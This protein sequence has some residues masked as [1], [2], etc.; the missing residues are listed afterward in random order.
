MGQTLIFLSTIIFLHCKLEGGN[1]KKIKFEAQPHYKSVGYHDIGNELSLLMY[2]LFLPYCC[3]LG[4]ECNKCNSIR[5]WLIEQR[6]HQDFYGS[7]DV[8]LAQIIGLMT[9]PGNLIIVIM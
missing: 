5:S 6:L 3:E 8:N 9:G 2:K 4:V 1:D 7:N